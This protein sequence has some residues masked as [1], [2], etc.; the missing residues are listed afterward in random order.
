MARRFEHWLAAHPE[1]FVLEAG[2]RMTPEGRFVTEQE[3]ADDAGMETVS[4]YEV[5]PDELKKWIAFL[6]S[7]GGFEVW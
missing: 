4:A 1:G 2:I 3:M 5:G 6:R 7:C